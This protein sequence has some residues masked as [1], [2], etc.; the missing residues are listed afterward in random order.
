MMES[1]R[2]AGPPGR[3][4]PRSQ[5]DTR[6][7]DTLREAANTGCET[8]SRSRIARISS[9]ASVGTGARHASSKV[10]KVARDT[11]P[12]SCATLNISWIAPAIS[13]RYPLSLAA[14][15]IFPLHQRFFTHNPLLF[16]AP[17]FQYLGRHSP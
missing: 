6:L 2:R 11:P 7:R 15:A 10:R 9:P 14:L 1:N 3:F 4:T 17:P 5:S 13:P 8:C 16:L 12:A